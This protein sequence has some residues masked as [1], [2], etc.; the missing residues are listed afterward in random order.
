MKNKDKI[1]EYLK[2]PEKYIPDGL[3]CYHNDYMCP[4]WDKKTGE[5]P[6]QEDGYC[7]FL[8]KSDWDL[9]EEY[10]HTMIISHAQD[11]CLEG[12]PIADIFEEDIDPISGKNTH[13]VS[14]LLWDQ[15][16][17]CRINLADP[18]DIVLITMNSNE[19]KK[20]INKNLGKV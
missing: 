10:K 6:H 12:L 8:G 15:C 20:I 16:K 9:N 18:E 17:E 4:F 13:F 14:S 19:I 2:T 5:Y 3:Y 7:Y 11:K 1:I